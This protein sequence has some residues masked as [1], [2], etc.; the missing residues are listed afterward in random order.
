MQRSARS[1]SKPWKLRRP[2]LPA[3]LTGEHLPG[4]RDCFERAGT[5]WLYGLYPSS[6]SEEPSIWG[7]AGRA[8][9]MVCGFST[10][11]GCELV[12]TPCRECRRKDET[13]EIAQRKLQQMEKLRGAFGIGADMA[14]GDAFNPEVQEAKRQA[15]RD[16]REAEKQVRRGVSE[17]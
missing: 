14:E 8:G 11:H 17:M 13:H 6:C 10:I 4:F 2:N 7:A 5:Q 16:R 3:S 12:A 9:T 1:C 15:E